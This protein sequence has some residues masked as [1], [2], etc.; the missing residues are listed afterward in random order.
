[1]SGSSKLSDMRIFQIFV[2]IRAEHSRMYTT[3]CRGHYVL[4]V[5]HEGI[6]LIPIRF[7][8]TQNFHTHVAFNLSCNVSVWLLTRLRIA[9]SAKF[10]WCLVTTKRGVHDFDRKIRNYLLLVW[11]HWKRRRYDVEA[12]FFALLRKLSPWLK[13]ECYVHPP[14]HT[15]AYRNGRLFGYHRSRRVNSR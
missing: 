6:H 8:E 2:E 15:A 4:E 10:S 12:S 13:G 11:F 14:L 5:A 1:M 9:S 3:F 7:Q